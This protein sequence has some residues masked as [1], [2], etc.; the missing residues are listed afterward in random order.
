[1]ESGSPEDDWAPTFYVGQ[2]ETKRSLPITDFILQQA[3]ECKVGSSLTKYFNRLTLPPQYDMLTSPITTDHFH[4]RILALLSNHSS[5]N[6]SISELEQYGGFTAPKIPGL[7]PLDTPLTPSNITS[8]LLAMTS[9][10]IDLCSPDP[11]IYDI[12][13]QVLYLEVA[14]AAFCGI[15]HVFVAGPR[16]Y[17]ANGDLH[18]NGLPQYARA[19]QEALNIGSHLQLHIMLPMIDHPD[20]RKH[21]VT[22]DLSA[23]ARDEYLDEL[24]EVTIK[25]ADI[26]GTWEAWNVIRTVCKYSAR[27]FVGKKMSTSSLLHLV[28]CVCFLLVSA[29]LSPLD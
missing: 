3:H 22:G 29:Y 26:F 15:E 9:P 25:K 19:I 23:L 1:M 7:S 20:D 8:Q 6:R 14:Y 18:T 16:L 5:E 4:N 17:H 27:L 12:S 2:H 11:L 13:R 24:D 21:E 10:W 28:P